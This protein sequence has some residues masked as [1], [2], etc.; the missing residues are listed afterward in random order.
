MFSRKQAEGEY[1]KTACFRELAVFFP[2]DDTFRQSADKV[3]RVLWRQEKTDQVR[4]R[5]IA[6]LVEREGKSVQEHRK[7]EGRTYI[8]VQWIQHRWK[9]LGEKVYIGSGGCGA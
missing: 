1:Y 7:R 5:T 4:S 8:D 2:C 9:A 6:N 3:N